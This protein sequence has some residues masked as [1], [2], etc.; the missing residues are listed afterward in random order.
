MIDDLEVIERF[1]RLHRAFE[2]EHDDFCASEL[3][4][5]DAAAPRSQF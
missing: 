3:E 2:A 1:A 4:L 5:A